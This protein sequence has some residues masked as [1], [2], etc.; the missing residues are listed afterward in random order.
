MRKCGALRH[1]SAERVPSGSSRP[2]RTL[3]Y[4]AGRRTDHQTQA[5]QTP[6]VWTCQPRSAASAHATCCLSWFRRNRCRSASESLLLD[7]FEDAY[8]GEDLSKS[9]YFSHPGRNG[10]P[11]FRRDLDSD[12]S[13]RHTSSVSSLVETATPFTLRRLIG[14]TAEQWISERLE[15]ISRAW[16]VFRF[17]PYHPICWI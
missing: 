5:A 6:D 15:E 11:R 12:G 2:H 8:M 3:E 14:R 13:M 10:G 9:G 7:G 16:R 4:W 1:R 17:V